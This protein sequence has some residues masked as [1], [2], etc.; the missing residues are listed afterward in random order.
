MIWVLLVGPTS[1][2]G[3]DW[4]ELVGLDGVRLERVVVFGGLDSTSFV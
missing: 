2:R 1:T 3:D 4:K